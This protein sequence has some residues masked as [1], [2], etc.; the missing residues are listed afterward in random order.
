MLAVEGIPVAETGAAAAALVQIS[1][2]PAGTVAH[3]VDVGWSRPAC[4]GNL[5]LVLE[6]VG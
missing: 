5:K 1:V 4:A 6:L 3:L 2:D